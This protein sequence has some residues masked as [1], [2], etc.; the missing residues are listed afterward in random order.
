MKVSIVT[1]SYNASSS[2]R[3]C[4]ESVLNQDYPDIEYIIV[5]GGSSDD[6]MEIVQEYADKISHISSESDEG[7]YDAMNKGMAKATGDIVAQLNADDFYASPDILSQVVEK[8]QSTGSDIVFGNLVYVPADDLD[9]VVRYYTADQFKPEDMLRGHMPPH[10]TFFVK[11]SLVDICGPYR[12]DYAICADF[13]WMVRLF[14][15]HGATYTHLPE[16]MVK[17]RKGGV[18][19]Q[20]L[21]STLTINKEML[22]ACRSNGLRTNL[23]MI[24]SKY[25]TKVF[26]LVKKPT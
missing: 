20:G 17:M 12:T 13:E 22:Q 18:S 2:I 14:H 15:T 1:I 23:P 7:I 4:I 3:T 11:R 6:T 5:D 8:F 10:P 26:Q 19:T 16:V 21:K 9:K 24:Y 25:L